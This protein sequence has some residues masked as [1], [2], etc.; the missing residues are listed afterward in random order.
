MVVVSQDAIMSLRKH[1]AFVPLNST[2]IA[3]L[4]GYQQGRDFGDVF[5]FN[6]ITNEINKREI[7]EGDLFII[8]DTN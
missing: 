8:S 3:I 2:E 6:T 1:A 4:G 5:T 7:G